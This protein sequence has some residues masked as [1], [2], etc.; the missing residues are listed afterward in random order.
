[1]PTDLYTN[2]QRP[3][4]TAGQVATLGG[5][6]GAGSSTL[7]LSSGA[8]SSGGVLGTAIH[9]GMSAAS[10]SESTAVEGGKNAAILEE[11]RNRNRRKVL[12]G[13]GASGGIG[14]GQEGTD[15]MGRCREV[16]E[17]STVVAASG[18]T[19][20][21]DL[22]ALPEASAEIDPYLAKK[23]S[24]MQAPDQSSVAGG[25]RPLPLRPLP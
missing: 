17:E 22:Q 14:R 11:H 3:K 7:G 24:G 6:R 25:L 12:G 15:E 4:A 20:R 8:G 23:I 21:T 19:S 18:L 1:M 5:L 9:T 10:T 13:T 2:P 16:E